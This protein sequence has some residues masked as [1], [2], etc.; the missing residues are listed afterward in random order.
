MNTKLWL[1]IIVGYLSLSPANAPALAV[2]IIQWTHADVLIKTTC[3][4]NF[5]C[6]EWAGIMLR[7]YCE[8]LIRETKNGPIQ[9][10]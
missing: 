2:E 6:T 5:A 4:D 8:T 7:E 10:F 3:H 1:A 9:I